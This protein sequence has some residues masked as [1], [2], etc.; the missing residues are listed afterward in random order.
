MALI[1]RMYV[2]T[3]NTTAMIVS[4]ST[5]FARKGIGCPILAA[6]A[7]VCLVAIALITNGK[8]NAAELG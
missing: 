8:V 1:K 2:Y 3:T 7:I 6:H 5:I 4:I